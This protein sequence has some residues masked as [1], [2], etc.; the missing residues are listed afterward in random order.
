MYPED[1]DHR[2]PRRLVR[3]IGIL[4][5]AAIVVPTLGTFVLFVVKVFTSF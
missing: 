5:V 2:R 3:V 1:D 4:V